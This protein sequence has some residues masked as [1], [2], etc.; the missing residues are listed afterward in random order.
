MK[1]RNGP[2]PGGFTLLE[3]MI[4]VAIIGLL[5]AVAVPNWAKT[6][7][8]AQTDACIENLSQIETAKQLWGLEHGKTNGDTPTDSDLFGVSLYMKEK[9]LCPAGGSYAINVI[10][11]NATCTITGH[12]L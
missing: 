7:V 12:T 11:T 2:A 10:G 8:R 9:P 3:I 6:R 4:V 1:T 5:L